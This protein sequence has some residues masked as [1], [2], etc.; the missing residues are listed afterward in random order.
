MAEHRETSLRPS[1]LTGVHTGRLTE[2]ATTQRLKMLKHVWR[3]HFTDWALIPS[4]SIRTWALSTRAK[5]EKYLLEHWDYVILSERMA[6]VDFCY[7]LTVQLKTQLIES[8]T[9][10]LCYYRT[11]LFKSEPG[12]PEYCWVSVLPVLTIH[13]THLV[14]QS[15][16]RREDWLKAPIC[17]YK[18]KTR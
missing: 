16:V 10:Q 17:I 4:V 13:F 7:S 6:C 5:C 9:C 1:R 3:R 15:P 2:E 8:K 11:G 14:S 12:G 18:I